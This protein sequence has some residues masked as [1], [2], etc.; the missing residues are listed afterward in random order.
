MTL[1]LSLILLLAFASDT[2]GPQ[3]AF[4][5]ADGRYGLGWI[6]RPDIRFALGLDGLSLWLFVLTSILMITAIAASWQS[7]TRTGAPLL[8]FSPGA[9]DRL[10]GVVRQP[11]C[12]A[13]LHLL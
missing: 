9:A 13:L 12:R 1:G 11:R 6:E 3:F 2:V 7:I 10:A 4:S 8:R 5:T